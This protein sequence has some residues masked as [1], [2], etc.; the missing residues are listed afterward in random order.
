MIIGTIV[1]LF[2]RLNGKKPA[3]DKLLESISGEKSVY[4]NDKE[5]RSEEKWLKQSKL[6]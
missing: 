5:I 2:C 4:L 3:N 1:E 6:K